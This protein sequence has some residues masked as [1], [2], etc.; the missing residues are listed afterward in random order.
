MRME[1]ELEVEV[2]VLG[3]GSAGE[4]VARVCAEGGLRVAV[5]ESHLVGGECP[6]LACIP[7]KS[8]LLS[9]ARR[10]GWDE[11]VQRRDAD[12]RHRDDTQAA[13]ELRGPGTLLLRGRGRVH[14]PGVLNVDGEGGQLR[15]RY[16]HLVVASGSVPVLPDLPGL[17][18]VPV[19]TSDQA[20]S[21]PGRPD[22][23]VILGGGPVGCELAQ[24][25]A[26][27]GTQ[28]TVV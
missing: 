6:Y 5:V 17:D 12:A 7:S 3:A 11:A 9:A 8:L 25:Y 10:V 23:M 27:F 19:W 1:P 28:V 4:T 2:A 16:Q 21:A 18:D 22:R 14:S 15:V 26:R 24:L 13:K 20:L